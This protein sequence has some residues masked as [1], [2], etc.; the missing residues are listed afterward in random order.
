[1]K[2]WLLLVFCAYFAHESF[3]HKLPPGG[4]VWKN[5]TRPNEV[6][7]CGSACQTECATLGEPCPIVNFRCNDKCYCVKGYARDGNGDCIKIED[8]PPKHK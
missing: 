5:C 6:Y 7:N 4:L 3:A 2:F 8:C 1:M